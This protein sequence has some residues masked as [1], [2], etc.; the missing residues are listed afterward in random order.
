MVKERII[1]DIIYQSTKNVVCIRKQPGKNPEYIYI[2]II[3]S[4]MDTH[5]A[6]RFGPV[7]LRASTNINQHDI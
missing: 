4:G 7:N 2:Y 1:L 5:K 3:I 6:K